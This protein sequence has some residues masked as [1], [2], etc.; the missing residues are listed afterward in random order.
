[1]YKRILKTMIALV[2]VFLI[3]LYIL[4]IF[5]PEQF[6]MVIENDNLIAIGNYVDNN[7]WLHI[8]LACVTSFITYWMYIC[9]VT[10]K[11]Y[12]NWKELIAVVVAIAIVQT[13]YSFESTTTLASGISIIS[14]IAIPLISNAKLKDVAIVFSV[15]SLSQILSTLIRGLPFLLTNVNYATTLLMTI[16]CYFWLLLFYLYFNIKETKNDEHSIIR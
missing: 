13:L 16:E 6:I 11:W 9:A 7:L 5:F 15:H 2:C 4:K 10:R 12:L 1:M 8:I 3:A 14:M